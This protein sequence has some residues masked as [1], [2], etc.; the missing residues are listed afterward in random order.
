ML[1]S[2]LGRVRSTAA[3]VGECVVGDVRL[4]V[5]GAVAAHTQVHGGSNLHPHRG[6][7]NNG[8]AAAARGGGGLGGGGGGLG[9]EQAIVDG[10]CSAGGLRAQP[11]AEDLRAFVSSVSA[12][13]GLKVGELMIQKMVSRGASCLGAVFATWRCGLRRWR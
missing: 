6:S 2:A 10:M 4:A 7:S 9:N 11:T 3:A 1:L 8:Y 12:L 13:D 5:C